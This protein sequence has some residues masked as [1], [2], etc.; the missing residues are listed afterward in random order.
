MLNTSGERFV[1]DSRVSQHLVI[2][3]QVVMR[4]SLKGPVVARLPAFRHG[5][6]PH[7]RCTTQLSVFATL[8][9][10]TRHIF[11]NPFKILA[12][13]FLF[14]RAVFICR[15]LYELLL[16]GAQ[17]EVMRILEG[18]GNLFGYWSGDRFNKRVTGSKKKKQ[19]R[20]CWWLET[21]KWNGCQVWGRAIGAGERADAGVMVENGM[22]SNKARMNGLA[23]QLPQMTSSILEASKDTHWPFMSALLPRLF[24]ANWRTPDQAYLK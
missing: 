5:C 1:W 6:G 3:K 10:I 8:K 23:R 18:T 22:M 11:A 15:A 2:L 13:N 9:W 7:T 17:N 19:N 24:L 16:D 12:Y 21:W 14:H 4:A 20:A